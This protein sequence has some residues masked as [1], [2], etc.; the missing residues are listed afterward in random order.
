MGGWAGFLAYG[1]AEAGEYHHYPFVNRRIF[2]AMLRLPPEY[3]RQRRLADD[4]IAATWPELLDFPF[5]QASAGVYGAY[6]RLRTFARRLLKEPLL[7]IRDASGT[8]GT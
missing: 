1:A 8:N 2:E 5:N 7:S 4:I 3:R 6:R